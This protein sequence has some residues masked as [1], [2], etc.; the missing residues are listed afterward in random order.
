M[1][2]YQTAKN[3][4]EN[5]L[6]TIGAF[7]SSQSQPDHNELKKALVWLEMILNNQAGISP[8]PGFWDIVEIPVQ[9]GIGDYELDDYVDDESVQHVFSA[10]IIETSGKVTPLGISSE[11]DT[12]FKDFKKTGTPEE[13]IVTRDIHP[14]MRVFPT[15]TRT[16]EDN[17]LV[18]RIRFQKFHAAIDGEGVNDI[19]ISLRPSWYLWL[20]KR[21]A[22]E[23]GSGP[24]R[25]LAESELNRIEKDYEKIETRLYGRDG[26]YNLGSPPISEPVLGS[27]F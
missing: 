22:Y 12:T 25:R 8:T 15:P 20:T 23:I 17:G 6:S 5:A 26:K 21:L 18:I 24:V 7:A 9:A 11:T 13:I 16:D 10:S 1:P 2:T 4:A 3:V 19:N 27:M 14:I